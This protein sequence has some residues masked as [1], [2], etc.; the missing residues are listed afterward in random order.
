MIEGNGGCE[1]EL[2]RSFI[3]RV[4]RWKVGFHQYSYVLKQIFRAV[5]LGMAQ[6]VLN[7]TYG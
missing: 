6:G 7:V 1:N 2:G 4:G 3:G 5:T